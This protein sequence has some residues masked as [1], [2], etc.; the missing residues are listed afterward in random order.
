MPNIVIV[1]GSPSKISRLNGLTEYAD[2]S[3]RSFGIQTEWI[4]AADLPAEALVKA[5][6][7]DPQIIEA[8]QRVEQADAVI[9]ASPVYKAAYTGVL[10]TYLDLLPQKGLLGK[11]VLPLFIGGSLAHYLTI[12]YALKP[13]LASLGARHILAGVYAV[14]SWVTRQEPGVFELTEELTE[15]LNESI[16]DLV[17]E[18]GGRKVRAV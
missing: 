16:H 2:N 8:N 11:S 5:K 6:F 3:L 9:I 13:V 18:L 4:Y 15:R 17:R 1:T 12:D 14:D 10:K 7:D